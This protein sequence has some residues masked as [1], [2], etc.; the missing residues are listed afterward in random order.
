MAAAAAAVLAE[1]GQ[2]ALQYSVSEGEP[3][4]REWIASRYRIK[5]NML[6]VL[7]AYVRR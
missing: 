2:A 3:A 6:P 1:S 7:P 5:K 4:L